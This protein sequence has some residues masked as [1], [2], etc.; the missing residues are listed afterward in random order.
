[1]KKVK[2]KKRL[3]EMFKDFSIRI[4][5]LIVV[6]ICLVLTNIP[7]FYGKEHP[8]YEPFVIAITFLDMLV[9][10]VGL[11][12]LRNE[13]RNQKALMRKLSRTEARYKALVNNAPVFFWA[14]DSDR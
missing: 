9:L 2:I 13:Y 3:A 11:F 4:R 5:V 14:V 8:F 10:T 12:S 6:M 1:M 7:L